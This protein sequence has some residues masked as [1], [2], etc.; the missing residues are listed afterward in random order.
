[1]DGDKL[2]ISY[3]PTQ[4]NNQFELPLMFITISLI[5]TKF[6]PSSSLRGYDLINNL[7]KSHK[8]KTL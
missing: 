4:F 2:P 7:Q 5:F 6:S 1:M 3:L 8:A